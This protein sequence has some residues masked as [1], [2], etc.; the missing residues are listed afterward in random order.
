MMISAMECYL[1]CTTIMVSQQ[2]WLPAQDPI[3]DQVSPNHT[4]GG[5]DYIQ[6]LA[7]TGEH[8]EVYS[9]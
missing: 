9:C 7:L 5:V 1:L 6:A 3:Q 8:L 4:I 2:V